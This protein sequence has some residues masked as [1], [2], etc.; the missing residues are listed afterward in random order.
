MTEQTEYSSKGSG[1]TLQCIDGLMLD[2][3]TPM[4]GSSYVPLPDP[5]VNKRATIN[6]QNLDIQCFK[7]AILARH[8]TDENKSRVGEN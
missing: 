6:P 3:Y 2:V 8:V 5:I 4:G 7:W 1:F